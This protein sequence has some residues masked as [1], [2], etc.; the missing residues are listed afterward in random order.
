MTNLPQWI[1][2]KQVGAVKIT[3]V[4]HAYDQRGSDN[5]RTL[6]GAWLE[7][8]GGIQISVD[9]KYMEKHNPKP[10]GYFVQYEDGYQ[11]FSPAEAFEKGYTRVNA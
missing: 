8:E 10:G 4:L 3:N 6:V 7:C 2:H 1:C 5:W 11:S 9:A